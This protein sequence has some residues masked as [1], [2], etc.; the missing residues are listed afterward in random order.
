M[1]AV[2][3]TATFARIRDLL[4]KIDASPLGRA[5]R[6]PDARH[7]RAC[8][9]LLHS[10]DPVMREIGEQVR[11]GRIRL[12]DVIRVPVY[13]EAFRN[14]TQQAIE[15]LDPR[16]VAEQLEQLAAQHRDDIAVRGNR[17]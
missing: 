1:D 11:D 9:A 14:A 12:A 2:E 4:H 15:Q 13:A 17:R 10:P 8:E 3:A 16:R 5:M 6:D 7:R